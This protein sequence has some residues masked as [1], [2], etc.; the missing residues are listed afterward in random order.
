MNIFRTDESPEACAAALDDLRL[1]KMLIE[2]AQI[3]CSAVHLNSPT[4]VTSYKPTHLRHPCVIWAAQS[5]ENFNW[6]LKHGITLAAEWQYRRGRV[7]ASATIIRWATHQSGNLPD[8]FPSAS[9]NCT[10]H[11]DLPLHEAYRQT[12]NDKWALDRRPP[13]WT[14]RGPPNWAYFS[15]Q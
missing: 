5:R 7:H 8:S 9:P 3:L 13:T 4:T 2:T 11:P 1:G 14:R 12:L 6:L 15:G 10:P